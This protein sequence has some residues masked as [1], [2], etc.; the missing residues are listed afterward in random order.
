MECDKKNEPT[1]S[2][3]QDIVVTQ[4]SDNEQRKSK[5]NKNIE[6]PAIKIE[7]TPDRLLLA[8]CALGQE[9]A[10]FHGHA[11]LKRSSPK[12]V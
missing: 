5:K 3:K 12:G 7:E 4:E 8:S 9:G 2:L 11:E 6:E 1:E 10:Y